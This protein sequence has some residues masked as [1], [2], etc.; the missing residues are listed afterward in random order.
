MPAAMISTYLGYQLYGNNLTQ[1]LARTAA[2]PAVSAA[3][4]YYNANIGKVK[5][6]A[7]LVDNYK[8]LSYATQAFGLSDMTYAK[9]LLTKVLESNLSDKTSVANELDDSR[10]TAFAAAFDFK[11]DG[12]LATTAQLQTTAQQAT[13]ESLF[14]A[15]T[16]LDAADA[17]AATTAYKSAI[18]S[19]TSLGQLEQNQAAFGYVLVA[20]GIDPSTA[21]ST[22]NQTLESDLSRSTS[23]VNQQADD[24]D[25]ALSKAFDVNADGSAA[26]T[27]E[28]ET[29]ANITA[30]TTAYLGAAATDAASQTAAATET[31]YFLSKIGSITSVSDLTSDSRLVAYVTKAFGL[32][33]TATASDIANALTS[34]TTDATSFAR[35]SPYPAYLALAKAFNFSTSGA[36]GTVT[37]FQTLSAQRSTVALYT[38]RQTSDTAAGAAATAY[39]NANIGK[40]KSVADLESDPKLLAYVKTAYGFDSSTSNATLASVIENT[41]TTTPSDAGLLALKLGFNVD[42][43][44]TATNA[45]TAESAANI[46]ATTTAYMANA[47]TDAA[48]QTAAKA[49]T[50]YYKSAIANVTSVSELLAD[51]KLVAY[52][53]Q[54]YDLPASTSTT[55]LQSILT[56]D[57]TNPKSVA[58]TMGIERPT[59]SPPPSISPAPASIAP[60]SPRR[61]VQG[62]A[63]RDQQRLHRPADGDG[64][65]RPEPRNRA[66]AL[67]PAE[68][69]QSHRRL[70]HPG[71]QAAVAGVPNHSRPA[72]RLGLERR[73]RCASQE[74][75]QPDQPGRSEEPD[76]AEC[77]DR[78]VL[79]P[80]RSST[81][82]PRRRL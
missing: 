47:K 1:S 46:S 68:C 8:L 32:P 14:Q 21:S 28:A 63:R 13:T 26:T 80:V 24:G 36:A 37:Q 39:Y 74:H 31:S 27:T 45:P 75:Q 61:P 65:R 29:D 25:L 64:G 18:G 15:N 82:R 10:Y 16:T 42:A 6:V 4:A 17:A 9:G 48:S 58:N 40:V 33:S 54:A 57:V 41:L 50:A 35:T 69:L 73:H 67:F 81:R 23:Y 66:R 77:P 43:T 34:D 7:D 2:E 44:G 56:S 78:T 30:T 53:E 60:E 52:V 5:T 49:A 62:A 79:H 11:S 70:Q 76:E 38:A 51:P 72:G 59:R 55:T 19:I 12:T 71:G 20:Y 3:E 22:F